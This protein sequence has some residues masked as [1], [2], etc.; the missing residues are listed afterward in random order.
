MRNINFGENYTLF[1][2]EYGLWLTKQGY[3]TKMRNTNS[4]EN[5]TLFIKEYAWGRN[6][7]T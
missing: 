6:K 1:I 4:E 3:N 7:R 2:K 5:Y